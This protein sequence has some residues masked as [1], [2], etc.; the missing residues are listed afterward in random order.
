MQR[1]TPICLA[2]L[3]SWSAAAHAQQAGSYAVYRA[4]ISKTLQTFESQI[5]TLAN[6]GNGCSRYYDKSPCPKTGVTTPQQGFINPTK[7]DV[8]DIKKFLHDKLAAVEA[9]LAKGIDASKL[10][11]VTICAEGPELA[12][13]SEKKKKAALDSG[14]AAVM[15][16][17]DNKANN[18][19]DKGLKQKLE[20]LHTD[21]ASF[22]R[23]SAACGAEVS[24]FSALSTPPSSPYKGLVMIYEPANAPG[25]CPATV[26]QTL[27]SLT[28]QRSGTMATLAKQLEALATQMKKDSTTLATMIAKTEG[29]AKTCPEKTAEAAEPIKGQ[30][31]PEKASGVSKAE[32]KKDE[33]ASK[34]SGVEPPK[35]IASQEVAEKTAPVKSEHTSP[36][37]EPKGDN[38][39]ADST[40]KFLKEI[41]APKTEVS[42]HAETSHMPAPAAEADVAY[43][44]ETAKSQAVKTEPAPTPAA[45]I[46]SPELAQVTSQSLA[47]APPPTPT[48]VNEP[49]Y[50]GSDADAFS[51]LPAYS[52]IEQKP[53]AVLESQ[54]MAPK[55]PI[56]TGYGP[57]E[58]KPVPEAPR[59]PISTGYGP[60]EEKP[61]YMPAPAAEADAAYANEHADKME[62]APEV[63]PVYMPAPAAEADVAYKESTGDITPK[64]T[65][66]DNTAL[67][68][69]DL[70]NYYQQNE[71][72][73]KRDLDLYSK[74]DTAIIQ[75]ALNSMQSERSP[76]SRLATDG[77]F[78]N[79]T[80]AR[81]SNVM[82]DPVQ[83]AAFLKALRVQ[84][85]KK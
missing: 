27:N 69:K 58:E 65:S 49:Y 45:E 75:R 38:N 15:K 23:T 36:V 2:L 68:S 76:A 81:L 18:S 3:L 60:V 77:L 1:I 6:F 20:E 25:N 83:K 52:D 11:N 8:N 31:K 51:S 22:K 80:A 28:N 37:S 34:P 19:N 72:L 64:I 5:N 59:V 50:T 41:E 73:K 56:S 62:T 24:S 9:E 61:A 46:H 21:S 7:N 10:S 33:L 57:V 53:P 78:G 12:V 79:Q 66:E 85:S 17:V 40:Q 84:M 55:V 82:S 26:L 48:P 47:P 14:Y 32:E 16:I 42:T 44:H 39:V 13:E 4:D 43:E 70:R 54:N 29:V 74:K 67:N 30:A 63:K 71:E 35:P